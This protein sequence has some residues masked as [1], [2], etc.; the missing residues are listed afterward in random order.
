MGQTSMDIPLIAARVL[1]AR[2]PAVAGMLVPLEMLEGPGRPAAH[3]SV[4]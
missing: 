2:V 3:R 1:L 4:E